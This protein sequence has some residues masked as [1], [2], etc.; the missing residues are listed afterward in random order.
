MLPPAPRTRRRLLG[1]RLVRRVSERTPQV[2]VCRSV[3]TCA[4]DT[5]HN[6]APWTRSETQHCRYRVSRMHQFSMETGQQRRTPQKRRFRMALLF[7]D[8][9]SQGLKLVCGGRVTTCGRNASTILQSSNSATPGLYSLSEL[10]A[11]ARRQHRYVLN[12]HRAGAQLETGPTPPSHSLLD[13][14]TNHGT[15]RDRCGIVE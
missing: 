11:R 13:R 7:L 1:V 6:T 5:R 9:L 2:T 14:R 3:R 4:P 8:I 15:P 10:S 12:R